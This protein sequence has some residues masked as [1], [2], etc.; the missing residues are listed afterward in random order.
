MKKLVSDYP[1]LVAEWH[2]VKNGEK[3]PEDFSYGSKKYIWWVCPSGHEYESIICNRTGKNSGCRTC[4]DQSPKPWSKE[5]TVNDIK[6]P[7]IEAAANANSISSSTLSGYFKKAGSF[8]INISNKNLTDY[9]FK[10]NRKFETGS[11]EHLKDISEKHGLFEL[12]DWY[13]KKIYELI[14]NSFDKY[15][16]KSYLEF[17][18]CIFPNRKIHFWKLERVKSDLWIDQTYLN[19]YMDWLGIQLGFNKI[20]DWYK[21][22]QQDLVTN[23]GYGAYH[24]YGS[25]PDL[26]KAFLGSSFPNP[27]KLNEAPKGFWEVKENQK[28]FLLDLGSKLNFKKPED[29]YSISSKNIHEH[30]GRG[31]LKHYGSMV[32]AIIQIFPDYKLLKWKFIRKERN[33]W[34]SYQNQK[35]FI[36]WMVQELNIKKLSDYYSISGQHFIEYGGITLL[37]YYGDSPGKCVKEFF[38]ELNLNIAE[39][40]KASKSQLNLYRF[41]KNK[42]TNTIIQYNYKHP[43]LLFTKSKRKM[44]LDLYFPEL[45]IGIEVQGEQHYRPAWGGKKELKK[46]LHRDKE[47]RSACKNNN[48]E[49]IE[50]KQKLMPMSWKSLDIYLLKNYNKFYVKLI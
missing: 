19:Q 44:E 12:E 5:V 28:L 23:Y 32:E 38:P 13:E 30:G 47:K 6:Y 3:K 50:I 33:Y 22:S 35:D 11:I 7:T 4:S 29:W 15:W 17:L 45:N 31:L 27:W 8:A 41:L 1:K 25:V 10:K 16:K 2:P 36:L 34:G 42:F 43:E 21:L 37:H 14:G 9:R 48:I 49:L 46:I 40:D 26:L 18:E 39:F 24:S 20:E